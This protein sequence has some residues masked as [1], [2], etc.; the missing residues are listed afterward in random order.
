MQSSRPGAKTG[1]RHHCLPFSGGFSAGCS[2]GPS[3]ADCSFRRRGRSRAVTLVSRRWT[4]AFTPPRACES[5][6]KTSPRS[7]MR[8]L[9]TGCLEAATNRIIVRR[10]S[11]T[12]TTRIPIPRESTTWRSAFRCVLSR[13]LGV[14]ALRFPFVPV[15]AR[16]PVVATLLAF[17]FEPS[18]LFFPFFLSVGHTF[19]VNEY[20]RPARG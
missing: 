5:E 2:P 20:V 4:E 6:L 19:S 11:F 3:P 9:G 16:G 12:G 14:G 13:R 1:S 7:G 17:L 10:W 15:F 18:P 8:F